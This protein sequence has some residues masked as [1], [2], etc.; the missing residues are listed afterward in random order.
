VTARLSGEQSKRRS[1]LSQEELQAQQEAFVEQQVEIV[2]G[3][4]EALST[5]P[6]SCLPTTEC[7]ATNELVGDAHA[8]TPLRG[9]EIVGDSA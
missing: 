2:L 3:N 5:S 8:L 6:L 7:V 4:V 9:E 1:M